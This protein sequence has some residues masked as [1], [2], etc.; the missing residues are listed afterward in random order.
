MYR[1]VLPV[2]PLDPPRLILLPEVLF[3][4]EQTTPSVRTREKRTSVDLG[5]EESPS[6]PQDHLHTDTGG[7]RSRRG[8]NFRGPEVHPT[9]G[10]RWMRGPC[11]RTVEFVGTFFTPETS[12]LGSP[13]I[14]LTRHIVR[15]VSEERTLDNF[16][17]LIGIVSPWGYKGRRR[18]KSETQT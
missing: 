6:T 1:D 10:W 2:S 17:S 3:V 15:E 13:D 16:R 4:R 8:T 12:I 5:L 14:T 9:S 18:E 11:R 7:R